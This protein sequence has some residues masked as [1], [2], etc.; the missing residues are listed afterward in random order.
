MRFSSASWAVVLLLPPPVGVASC[1]RVHASACTSSGVGERGRVF[2]TFSRTAA[3]KHGIVGSWLESVE[4]LSAAET[5]GCLVDVI[6][7][8]TELAAVAE[9]GR[10]PKRCTKTPSNASSVTRTLIPEVSGWGGARVQSNA[11]NTHQECPKTSQL[12]LSECDCHP[13]LAATPA[14]SRKRTGALLHH[15]VNKIVA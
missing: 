2:A 1:A 11:I 3:H 7:A 6:I 10:R 14:P 12:P 4:G 5:Q 9:L 13:R 8:N 15:M